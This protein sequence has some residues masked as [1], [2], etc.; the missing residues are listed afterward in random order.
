MLSTKQLLNEVDRVLLN[1]SETPRPYGSVKLK[2]VGSYRIR[3]GDYRII[4]DINDTH[5]QIT[6]LAIGH[7]REIYR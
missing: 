2:G 1:L 3:I 6:I 7:R 5:R 4:Y